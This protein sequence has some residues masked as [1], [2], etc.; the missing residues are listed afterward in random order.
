MLL[1]LIPDHRNISAP[2]ITARIKSQDGS[3]VLANITDVALG[4]KTAFG[5]TKVPLSRIRRMKNIANLQTLKDVKKLHRFQISCNNG[6]EIVGCPASPDRIPMTVHGAPK[7]N[8][9]RVAEIETLEVLE[10]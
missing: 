1:G 6:N 3:I 10:G 7:R 9:M 4:F 8:S 5:Y 2:P